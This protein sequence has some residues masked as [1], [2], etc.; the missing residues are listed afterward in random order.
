MVI[1]R[2][3]L[4]RMRN[5]SDKIVEKIK[6]HILCSVTFI[7]FKN[8][9][10]YKIMWKNIVE[11]GMPHMTIGCMRVAYWIPEAA[12]T[13]AQYLIRIAFSTETMVW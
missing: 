10:V 2:S 7:V 1:S 6:T 11:R 4:L 8:R 12:N 9:T 5:C 3:V 13:H